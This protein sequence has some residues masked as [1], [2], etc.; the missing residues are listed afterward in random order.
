MNSRSPKTDAFIFTIGHSNHP[1]EKFID[2]LKASRID[3]LVDVRS[4]PYSK[5]A[6][7]FDRETLQT[8]VKK[9]GMKYLFL[10]KELGGR[11]QD[12]QFYDENGYV[13]YS[14]I[15][16]SP[17]F[18]EG[19]TTLENGIRKYRVAIM[20][21]E[22]SPIDCHRRLLVGRVFESRGVKVSHIRGDGRVQ[23]KQDLALEEAQMRPQNLQLTFLE[24]S[25][26]DKWKST[27]SVSLRR[28]PPNSLDCS[29]GRASED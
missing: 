24:E 21:S 27:R 2:L 10:G 26:E 14:R 3:V 18:L 28:Q 16:Q 25:E 5:H 29:E 15:A 19:I 20:C 22:E 8:E 11:P 17:E 6:K 1:L 23:S 9:A 4:Q 7:H 13:L 12:E